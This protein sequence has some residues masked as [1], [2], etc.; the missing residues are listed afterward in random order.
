MSRDARKLKPD[1]QSELRRQAIEMLWEG[2]SRKEVA[3]RLSVHH[4][5]VTKWKKNYIQGGMEALEVKKRGPKV[6]TR[7]KLFPKDQ[8]L[9][10]R[11]IIDKRPEQIKMEFALW[12]REVVQL[13]IKEK[14][15]EHLHINQ[16]GKY[17]LA[18]G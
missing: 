1:T 5:T 12:A 18:S 2:A 14:T 6:G 7:K 16:V 15:G 11:L 10:Q 9:I 13:L 3:K 17:P 8:K 4:S